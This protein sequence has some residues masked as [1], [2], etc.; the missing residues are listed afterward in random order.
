MK[1]F[2]LVSTTVLFFLEELYLAFFI[3]TCSSFMYA[4]SFIPLKIL[5]TLIVRSWANGFCWLCI[6]GFTF[7]HVLRLSFLFHGVGISMGSVNLN[8]VLILVCEIPC[9][10]VYGFFS[11]VFLREGWEGTVVTFSS[12]A[13]S[14][15]YADRVRA[16]WYVSLIGVLKQVV[17][18][19]VVILSEHPLP[20]WVLPC[21]SDLRSLNHSGC[22]ATLGS[23]RVWEDAWWL[24][25]YFPTPQP[26]Y[27]TAAQNQ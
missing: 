5:I 3:N 17:F 16:G 20:P 19:V 13:T 14:T 21:V 7:F 4:I 6:F 22:F 25:F 15:V 2:I 24:R 11:A 12:L 10:I 9:Y 18:W 1:F 8:W 27:S 26:L 23:Q